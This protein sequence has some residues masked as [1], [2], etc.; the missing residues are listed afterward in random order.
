M[1]RVEE[2]LIGK[3][4][5]DKI[6]D[7]LGSELHEKDLVTVC[8]NKP[9]VFQ[10]IALQ[11]GGVDTPQG[12]TPAVIR[13]ICDMNIAGVPGRPFTSILKASNPQSDAIVSELMKS[14]PPG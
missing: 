2:M 4:K 6:Y 9:L 11:A 8:P 10:I 5:M 12:K 14:D 13:I 7:C 1:K 3:P